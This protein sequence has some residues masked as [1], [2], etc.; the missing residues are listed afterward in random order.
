MK[1]PCTS[2]SAS[3]R[4]LIFITDT[5]QQI[6]KLFLVNLV[7]R[8]SDGIVCVWQERDA[9]E[10]KEGDYIQK[11]DGVSSNHIEVM[12]QMMV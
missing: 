10:E 7:F 9:W 12:E 3:D 2:C 6:I 5:R 11:I 1:L 8:I 4:S